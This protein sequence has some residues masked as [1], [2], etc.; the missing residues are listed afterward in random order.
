MWKSKSPKKVSKSVKRKVKENLLVTNPFYA[1]LVKNQH[2]G[3]QVQQQRVKKVKKLKKKNGKAKKSGQHPLT[4][5]FD[6]PYS[7]FLKSPYWYNVRAKVLKRDGNKCVRCPNK[8]NLQV[9]HKTY[10]HHFNEHQHLEDL[11]T[12]CDICH[13][14]EHNIK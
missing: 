11:E 6:K 2:R 8:K 13:K 7:V 1:S 12:L 4:H 9:H 10:I 14:A 3:N 5:L